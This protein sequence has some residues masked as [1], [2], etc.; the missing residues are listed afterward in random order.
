MWID[1]WC[2]T[3]G[4]ELKDLAKLIDIEPS[5]LS[6]INRGILRAGRKTARRIVEATNGEVTLYEL[7]N[8][9]REDL[10]LPPRRRPRYTKKEKK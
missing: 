9:T 4:V 1:E 3:E 10:Q 8:M 6:R 7:E 2:F 5:Y